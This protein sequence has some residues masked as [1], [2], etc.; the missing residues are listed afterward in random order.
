MEFR[1]GDP[2][3]DD[4]A[5]T[6]AT[7][8]SRFGCLTLF[9]EQLPTIDIGISEYASHHSLHRHG[10]GNWY[11]YWVLGMGMG[12]GIVKGIDMGMKCTKSSPN[13]VG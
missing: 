5:S 8:N 2:P 9:G 7:W 12:M 6:T 10:N 3:I 4:P 11:G 1:F 13:I